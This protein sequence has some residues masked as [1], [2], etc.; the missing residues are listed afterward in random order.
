MSSTAELSNGMMGT[1]VIWK[2]TSEMKFTTDQ[3]VEVEE[4]SDN[5]PTT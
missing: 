4:T 1:E 3:K 2:D 5:L